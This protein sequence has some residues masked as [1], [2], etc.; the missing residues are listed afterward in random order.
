MKTL[1]L[2]YFGLLEPLVQTQVLPYLRALSADGIPVTLLTFEPDARRRWPREAA[3]E[4]R[5]RLE[6]D[7]IRWV[8]RVYH[9]RPSALATAYDI[10]VGAWAAAQLIRRERIE[11]LHARSHVPLA[12][13]LLARNAAPCRLVFDLRGLMAEEY[14]ASG[15]WGDGSLRFRAVKWVERMGLRRADGI[16]VLTERLR[17]WLA[18]SGLADGARIHVIPCCVDVERFGNGA[19]RPAVQ[20]RFEIVYVGSV[21]GLYLLEEMARFFLAFRTLEP[22]AVLRILTC[23]DAVAAGL[24]LDR[25]GVPAESRWIGSVPP[26]DIPAQLRRARLG[27]SFRRPTFAQVAACPTKIPE[28]LAAGLPVVSNEGIGDVD[29]LL[30]D[31]GV[32][33]VVRR[34]DPQEYADAALRARSLAQEPGIS[35][36]CTA[37]AREHFDLER[38]GGARYRALYRGLNRREPACAPRG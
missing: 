35:D 4:W 17:G 22:D 5:R 15:V 27:L 14:A 1:Y 26:S 25:L 29:H 19:P 8:F 34:F 30:T 37:A 36:R 2:C 11:V 12:M 33:V 6:A 21:T 10:V 16:V 23:G 28:Y 7:G 24:S 18:G 13:A 31:L 3:D 32:G 20:R 9:K 38:I